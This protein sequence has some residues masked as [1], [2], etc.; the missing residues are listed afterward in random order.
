MAWLEGTWEQEAAIHVAAWNGTSWGNV[1]VVSGPSRAPQLALAGAVL[2]DDS[3]LLLWAGF[4]G[5][6]DEI[7]WSRRVDERWSRPRRL[8]ADNAV[9]DI[10]PTVVETE[11]GALAAWSFYDGAHYR[12]RTARWDGEEWRLGPVLAGR[13]ALEARWQRL[14]QR[15]FLTYRTVEPEGW[16]LAEAEDGGR[17]RGRLVDSFFDERPLVVLKGSAARLRWPWRQGSAER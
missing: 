6:D 12:V 9:P 2:S 15:R 7:W 5:S 1:E 16:G 14:D 13:G 3:W 10:L 11:D 4:D 17:V 8:H